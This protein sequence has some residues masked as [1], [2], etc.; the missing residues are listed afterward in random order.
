[1]LTEWLVLALRK[2]E[3]DETSLKLKK[4]ME[5]HIGRKAADVVHP[6]L[7]LFVEV[8]RGKVP[9][10]SDLEQVDTKLEEANLMTSV[11]SQG[12]ALRDGL[13]II[14]SSVKVAALLGCE[15]SDSKNKA[16][17]ARLKINNFTAEQVAEMAKALQ[18]ITGY[19]EK[20]DLGA[21]VPAFVAE[22][23][24]KVN[25]YMRT[26][27]EKY[28]TK[29]DAMEVDIENVPKEVDTISSLDQINRDFLAKNFDMDKS[30]HITEKCLEMKA[31][32]EECDDLANKF[33]MGS[34]T[35][36]IDLSQYKLTYQKAMH[37]LCFGLLGSAE[38]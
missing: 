37:F 24:G 26:L 29:M 25:E 23:L 5:G 7:D 33:G 15:S 31:C 19:N 20:L 12:A 28:I 21:M 10:S 3:L 17:K 14:S 30:K 27:K 8:A 1:M 13:S 32:F 2:N 22:I 18:H 34:V 38:T 16:V 9:D 35:E 11:L 36:F 4:C 6:C